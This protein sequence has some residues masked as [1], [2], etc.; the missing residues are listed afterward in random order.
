ARPGPLSEGQE[1]VVPGVAYRIQ[2]GDTLSR[3]ATAFGVSQA[4]LVNANGIA[5]R[6]II[7]WGQ[8]LIIPRAPR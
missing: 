5:N 8:T 4:V 3:I 1:L 2:P 6:N 7:Y